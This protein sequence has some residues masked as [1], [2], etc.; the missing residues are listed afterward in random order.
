M[1]FLKGPELRFLLG[2]ALEREV[3]PKLSVTDEYDNHD[4]QQH[5]YFSRKLESIA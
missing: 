1:L 4:Q 5:R 2:K 3:T